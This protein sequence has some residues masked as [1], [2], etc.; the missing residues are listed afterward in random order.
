MSDV[1]M[2]PRPPLLLFA[3]LSLHFS[4]CFLLAAASLYNTTDQLVILD[5]SNFSSTVHGSPS[6]W[7]VEFYSSWCGHCITFAPTWRLFGAHLADWEHTVK[8]GVLDCAEDDNVPIC[9][10]HEVMGY[11]T[12]ML[13]AARTN[14]GD[15]GTDMKRSSTIEEMGNSVIDFLVEKQRA[16]NGS[17]SWVNLQPY[18]GAAAD[19]WSEVRNYG[20]VEH[21]IVIVDV[22]KSYRSW[23]T[24][25]DLGGYSTVAVRYKEVDINDAREFGSVTLP[26]VIFIDKTGKEEVVKDAPKTREELK[27]MIMKKLGLNRGMLP[28]KTIFSGRKTDASMKKDDVEGAG[29]GQPEEINSDILNYEDDLPDTAFTGTER[30]DQVYMVDIENAISYALGHEVIQFKVISGEALKSL[31]EFLDVLVRYLPARPVVHKFLSKLYKYT[32]S[33]GDNINGAQFAKVMKSI[34]GAD[35]VLPSHQPWIGC[36]GSE[37][38]Y[39]GYPCGLWTTFHV[40]TV[41][42]VLQDGNSEFY[43]PKKT[44][45]AIHGYVKHFFSCKYCSQHFQEMYAEDA[46]SSVNVADDGILWLWRGHNKVNKR[47]KGDATEDLLH[48]KQQFPPKKS[49]PACWNESEMSVKEVLTYMKNIYAKGALSFRGTQTISVPLRN[50]LAK[51]REE[52]DKH[53][54]KEKITPKLPVNKKLQNISEDQ[55]LR[56]LNTWGFNST[57]VSLC[58]FLYGIST[59]IIM[60][61]YCMVVIRRKMRRRRF[62]EAYKLPSRTEDVNQKASQEYIESIDNH[63]KVEE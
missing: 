28:Y 3:L 4:S 11:P 59:V 27:E 7:V 60:C 42:A 10:E 61:V 12:V 39:R 31:Q 6:A 33:H 9:R 20:T 63:H 29:D 32:L 43:N 57:D 46:E 52:L 34:Q 18:R 62:L 26:V 50:K 54:Q 14:K 45:R 2:E 19:A 48:P 23:S 58:V 30:E 22:P 16:N 1:G 55:A 41:N 25:L 24:I 53:K 56:P 5:H 15:V 36:L 8:V 49:C 47:L 35:T 13:F 21:V 37:P 51:V 40:L 44:L 17:S 38:R